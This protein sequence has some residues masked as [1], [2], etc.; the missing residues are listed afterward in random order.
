MPSAEQW[1]A[2]LKAAG[3]KRI[4]MTTWECP[5]DGF[6][7]RGPYGAWVSLKAKEKKAEPNNRLKE[8]RT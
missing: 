3:W 2:E 1:I 6:L 7:Y 5:D 8:N 4:G